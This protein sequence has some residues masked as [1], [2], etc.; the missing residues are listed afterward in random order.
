MYV[1]VY[2]CKINGLEVYLNNRRDDK[3]AKDAKD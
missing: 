3:D 2:K 1:V